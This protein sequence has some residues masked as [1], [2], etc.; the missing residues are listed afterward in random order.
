MIIL[1]IFGPWHFQ[2][3]VA[4][5]PLLDRRLNQHEVLKAKSLPLSSHN[6]LTIYNA[7]DI[8]LCHKFPFPRSFYS[9][10]ILSQPKYEWHIPQKN[11]TQSPGLTSTLVIPL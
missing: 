4:P 3:Q 11:K 2:V 1:I 5:N 7:I 6:Q 9:V 8:S 10:A